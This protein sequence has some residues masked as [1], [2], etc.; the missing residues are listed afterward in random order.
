MV[1][2]A[3]SMTTHVATIAIQEKTQSYAKH[4]SKYNFI[5]FAIEIYGCFYF[6]FDAFLTSYVQAIITRH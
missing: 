6:C 2:H 3:S 5:P 4:P 1:Q